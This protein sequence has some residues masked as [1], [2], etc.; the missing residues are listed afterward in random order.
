MRLAVRYITEG[1]IIGG[2]LMSVSVCRAGVSERDL[3]QVEKQVRLQKQ[4]QKKLE[5]AAEQAGKDLLKV[6]QE[7]IKAA[8]M[9]QDNE[10]SISQM[11]DRLE[12]LEKDYQKT[13]DTLLLQDRSLVKTISALQSLAL[14]PTEAL[15]VQPLTPVDIVRSAMLL[16]ET[17]PYL[18]TQAEIIKQELDVL[19]K[20]REII[21]RQVK[22]IVEQKSLLEREHAQMKVLADRK[23]KYRAQVSQQSALTKK[24]IEKLA[25]QAQDLRDLLSKLEKEKVRKAKLAAEKRRK[26]A[27]EAKRRIM[28]STKSEQE[29][30]ADLIKFSPDIINETGV[31]FIKAKGTLS[32]PVRGKI[33]TRYGEEMSK[34]VS[35]K[36]LTFQ[37]RDRAQVIAPFDGSV[38]FAGPFRGYG[39]LII[40]EH[41]KGYTSLLAG[42]DSIDCETGQMLLAGEPVGQMPGDGDARLYMEL[43]KDNHPINP[44]SWIEK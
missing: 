36:G 33:V 3:A 25:G 34:G 28:S 2:L 16:R 12:Q 11:E 43:R 41:G 26:Q 27:E 38:L 30:T 1:L 20:K 19:E 22:K 40:I 7:M 9:I 29:K 42:L 44:E 24:K 15:F 35:S 8:R 31:S 37:T 10:E 14:K 23:A 32:R 18:E 13:Q 39:N 17:V 5:Q 21:R 4:E 6:N